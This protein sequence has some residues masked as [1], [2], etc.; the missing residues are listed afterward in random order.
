MAGNAFFNSSFFGWTRDT[1]GPTSCN[2]SILS[3]HVSTER[4][5]MS[6]QSTVQLSFSSA[7]PLVRF[8]YNMEGGN[9]LEIGQH[10]KPKK[11]RVH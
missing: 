4:G 3:P 1:E 8:F 5:I 11:A 9:E 2:V 7:E 10:E 6:N